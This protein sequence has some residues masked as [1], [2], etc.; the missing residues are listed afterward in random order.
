MQVPLEAKGQCN[1]SSWTRVTGSSE[2]PRVGAENWT[3]VLLA[4]NALKYRVFSPACGLLILR[5][6]YS[7]LSECWGCSAETWRMS[8]LFLL[9]LYSQSCMLTSGSC[10]ASLSIESPFITSDWWNSV[11][12]V[13]VCLFGDFPAAAITNAWLHDYSGIQAPFFKFILTLEVWSLSGVELHWALETQGLGA[14]GDFIL[15]RFLVSSGDWIHMASCV[16]KSP[17]GSICVFSLP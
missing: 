8:M 1:G 2:M 6:T 14:R 7:Q 4:K 17:K 3:K 10:H 13:L 9:K 16:S 11:P 5:Q 15:R 12:K